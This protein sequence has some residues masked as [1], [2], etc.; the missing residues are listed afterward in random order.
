MWRGLLDL[1]YVDNHC[2]W[3]LLRTIIFSQSTL[4]KHM[5]RQ[6][7]D[8]LYLTTTLTLSGKIINCTEFMNKDASKENIIIMMTIINNDSYIHCKLRSKNILV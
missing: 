7:I 2:L 3:F 4:R 6:K 8:Q 1:P 5:Q